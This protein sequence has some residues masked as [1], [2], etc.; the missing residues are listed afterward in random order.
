MRT[1]DTSEAQAAVQDL[2]SVIIPVY[3]SEPFL[4]R[5]IDSILHQTYTRLEVILVDDGSTDNSG[6]MCD[7]YSKLDS[8]VQVIHTENNG[9]SS[10]RNVG[11][12]QAK[13]AF[14]FFIDSDDYIE[15][16][17]L[18]T[19]LDEQQRSKAD[20]II[21]DFKTIKDGQTGPGHK[22][23]FPDNRLLSKEEVVEYA[24]CYLRKP[25]RFTL[26]AYSWGRLFRSSIIKNNHVLFEA[27]LHTYEDVAFNF[28]YMMHANEVYY[29]KETIYFHAVHDNYT[30][31]TMMITKNPKRMFGYRRALSNIGEFIKTNRSDVDVTSEIGHANIFLTIIQFVRICGQINRDNRGYIYGLVHAIVTDPALRTKLKHYT[32]KDGDSKIVPFLMKLKFVRPIIWL[33]TYKAYKRYGKKVPTK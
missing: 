9:P 11:L 26:F 5:C 31:A 1:N 13:G 4:G 28:A 8:R 20:T 27:D 29:L 3:N 22:G 17:A 16:H 23:A 25:N 24:R 30:S 21:G 7:T 15:D 33:C 2:V 14:I 10:A 19:L 18:K 12:F 6:N 32:P